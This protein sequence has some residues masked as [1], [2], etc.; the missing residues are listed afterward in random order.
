MKAVLLHVKN[1]IPSIPV[2]YSTETKETYEVLQQVLKDIDY[3]KADH[4]WRICCD[5]K[6][7]AMLQG[8]QSGYT[9]YMCFLCNWDS[10]YAGNQYKKRDWQPRSVHKVGKLNVKW[11]KLVE[12]EKV[13]L[14][15]LHIKLGIVK[16]FIKTV[17]KNPEVAA[18]L[19]QI[20]GRLSEAKLKE[21]VLNGPDIRKLMKN[22]SF[23]AVLDPPDLD[24]WQAIK[25]VSNSVLGKKRAINY[26]ERVEK[27]MIAFELIG[28]HMSL[29]IHFLHFHLDYFG[30]Q[31]STESD[32][33]GER[34]HQVAMPFEQRYLEVFFKNS[35]LILQIT[36][37][38]S[39]HRYRGK[40]RPD[41]ILAEICWW[42]KSIFDGQEDEDS[43]EDEDQE[44]ETGMCGFEQSDD[45]DDVGAPSAVDTGATTS[46]DTGEPAAKKRK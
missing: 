40:K 33:Q 24:A 45:D 35:I 15:P 7:V 44:G 43:D 1:K 4:Q 17:Y 13:I 36:S 3:E 25:D 34:Y 31:L 37:I 8:L 19:K 32:E 12:T 14:P 21:G 26:K 22:A 20:F 38:F 41:A 18:R 30:H 27:M 39:L 11:E 2:A 28:V 46:H 23:E 6:V 9:K 5:L 16:S 42:S 29:K 10:R